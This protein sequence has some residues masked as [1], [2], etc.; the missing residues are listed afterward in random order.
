MNN[1]LERLACY[2]LGYIICWALCCGFWHWAL[3]LGRT[4]LLV[5]TTIFAVSGTV[6]SRVEVEILKVK[7]KGALAD[8]EDSSPPS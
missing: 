1:V 3:D 4:G 5:L 7:L 6:M 2:F 8:E